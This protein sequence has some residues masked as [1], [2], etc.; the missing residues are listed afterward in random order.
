MLHLVHRVQVLPLNQTESL[1]S[2][3]SE[4]QVEL[5]RYVGSFAVL[6]RVDNALPDAQ[7]VR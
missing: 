7:L 1:L 6:R 2:G 3:L 5:G 4:C